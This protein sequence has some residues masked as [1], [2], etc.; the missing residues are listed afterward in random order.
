MDRTSHHRFRLVLLPVFGDVFSERVVGVR[1]AEQRLDTE[2]PGAR[3]GWKENVKWRTPLTTRCVCAS[4]FD[5]ARS[6]SCCRRNRFTDAPE[7]HCPDLEGR[8]PLVLQDV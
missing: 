2:K 7:K 5:R 6:W 4:K 1:S 3:C 8:A